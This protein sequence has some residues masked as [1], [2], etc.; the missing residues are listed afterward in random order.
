MTAEVAGLLFERLLRADCP[1]DAIHAFDKSIRPLGARSVGYGFVRD[2]KKARAWST[3]PETW[4]RRYHEEGLGTHDPEFKRETRLPAA[5]AIRYADGYPGLGAAPG[6]DRL[7]EEVRAHGFTGTLFLPEDTGAGRR[8]MA[9]LNV[10]TDVP[11]RS[12]ARWV[13]NEG[14][15]IKLMAMAVLPRV[16]ALRHAAE[17]VLSTRETEVLELLAQGHRVARIANLAG[18][19]E[20]TVDFHVANARRKL[21]AR[22]RDQALALA[23]AEGLVNA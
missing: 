1:A 19:S 9:T 18:M 6:L 17:P 13:A 12:F 7:Y 11:D 22:T 3:T 20:R 4:R 21:G 2:G 15:L 5:A 23:V 8:Q 16:R 10:M 14:A